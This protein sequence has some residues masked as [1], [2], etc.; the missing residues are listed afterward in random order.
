[1]LEAANL[2][3]DL[4]RAGIEPWAWIVNQSM[5]GAAPSAPLLRE[6][7]ASELRQIDLV[8]TKHARRWA[9][10]PMQAFEPVGIEQLSR[11]ARYPLEPVPLDGN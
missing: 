11:L 10:V 3:D 5:A 4:R 9:I 7:A 2:Q 8:A 1:V 6:R